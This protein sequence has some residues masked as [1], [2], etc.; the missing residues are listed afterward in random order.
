MSPETPA[1]LPAGTDP[2]GPAGQSSVWDHRPDLHQQLLDAVQCAIIAT[3]PGGTIVYWNR[4][5]EALYGWPASEVVGRHVI[6]VTVPPPWREQATKIMDCLASGRPWCGELL[7]QRRDGITF[8]ALVIDSPI[9]DERGVLV[10]TVGIWSS[11]TERWREREELRAWRR[12]AEVFTGIAHA[13]TGSLELGVV[14]QRVVEGAR[15]LCASDTAAIALRDPDADAM[16]FRY[17]SGSRSAEPPPSEPGRGVGGQ[18]LVTGRPFRTDD[19]ARDPRFTKDY[20]RWA[21]AEGIAATMAVPI[22]IGGRIEGL[23]YIDNRPPR[24]FTDRE[25]RILT[26]IAD[27]AATAI[28]NA[29]LFEEAQQRLRETETLLAVSRSIGAT[30]DVTETMRLVARALARALGADM[31][32]TYLTDPAGHVLRPLAGYRVPR[33]V[34]E[35]FRACPFPLQGHPFIEQARVSREPVFTSEAGADP[36]IDRSSFE[37][38]PHQSLLF[39]PMFMKDEMIGGIAALWWRDARTFTAGE[40]HLADGIARQAALALENARLYESQGRLLQETQVQRQEAIAL[41]AV[42]RDLASS[43][44]RNEILTRIVAHARTLC[45]ADLAF[46][47]AYDRETDTA[48]IVAAAGER[49]D[50]LFGVAIARGRGMGGRILQTGEAVETDD[51]LGDPRF[52]KDYAD[53]AIAEGVV[54]QAVVPLR[55]RNTITGLLCAANRTQRSF[56]PGHL[57]VLGRLADQAAI[58]LENSRLYAER[59]RVEAELQARAGQQAAIA[60]LGQRALAGAH[61]EHLMAAA[62]RLVAE[63]LDVEYAKVL[64]L[65]PDDRALSLRAGVGWKPGLVGQATVPASRGSQAGYTLFAGRPVIVENLATETRFTGPALLVEHGVVS[66]LSVVIRDRRRPFGVLGAH[67]TRQRTFTQDDAHF[68]EAVANLLATG[69]ARSRA[70]EELRS[71]RAQLRHLAAHLHS[72][73]EEQGARIAR[74]IHDELGQTLTALSIDISTLLRALAGESEAV[75][76]KLGSMAALVTDTIRSVRRIATELRPGVLDDLGLSAAIEWQ[77]QDFEARTGIRC[78]LTASRDGIEIGRDRAT[79]VFRIFQEALTNVARHARATRVDIRLA[80]SAGRLVLVVRD[81]GTG[82]TQR[83][84]SAAT[85]LGLLGMRERAILLGGEVMIHGGRGGKGTTVT[86]RMPLA[87]PEGP[88]A[89]S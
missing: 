24:A 27:H 57:A 83:E 50:A 12:E 42:G 61:P 87:D 48:R 82:I 23:L 31:A 64:E 73:R 78:A 4:F 21:L 58:T 2:P 80:R 32:G 38:F 25:E 49:S 9:R 39:T 72:V 35:A 29:G 45:G 59:G 10:G 3:D 88:R 54:A 84:I 89:A 70:E 85:S 8:P 46:L 36:R 66:G 47:A 20:L 62:V 11:V 60:A 44:H 13:I 30:L 28:R 40:L 26:V 76:D 81:D 7:V 1:A 41:E 53:A 65:L 75:V 17:R 52:S 79:A 15:E 56:T 71:S 77:T 22:L 14:L 5:A 74:E 55:L 51:Y 18:V 37:Q 43:L 68:L 6:D 67:T 34:L 33:D 19:Y 63:T 16:V 69:I 86:L